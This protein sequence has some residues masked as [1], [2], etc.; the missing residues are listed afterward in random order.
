MLT[1]ELLSM[2]AA[3]NSLPHLRLEVVVSALLAL[4]VSTDEHDTI[5]DLTNRV[6]DR[7]LPDRKRG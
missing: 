7:Y 1:Q 5:W 2:I 3:G 6:C 4:M